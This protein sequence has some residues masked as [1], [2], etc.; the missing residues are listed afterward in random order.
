MMTINK[1][2]KGFA[3]VVS[4][5]LLL[6]MTVMGVAMMARSNLNTNMSVEYDRSEHVFMA[7]EAG[8]EH[9]RRYLENESGQNRYP[10]NSKGPI[11]SIPK[12][13][14][15]ADYQDGIGQQYDTLG[16]DS[17]KYAYRFPAIQTG[18]TVSAGQCNTFNS[19]GDTNYRRMDCEFDLQNDSSSHADEIN[20]FK[21]F[22]FSYY[23]FYEG[24]ASAAGSSTSVGTGSVGTSTAYAATGKGTAY[25]YKVISCGASFD[26]NKK[27]KQIQSLEA[28]IK[29]DK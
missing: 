4:L 29:L 24:E 28:R 15:L 9:A 12:N 3:L 22:G 17:G 27:L 21:R 19:S 2:Q 20:F 16:K 13:R 18:D 25:Y 7:A 23:I 10:A 5:L 11:N 14:C 6:M 8:I 26:K 1:T